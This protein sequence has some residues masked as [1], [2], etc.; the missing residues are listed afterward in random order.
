VDAAILI[1]LAAFCNPVKA[2]AQDP[3]DKRW[4]CGRLISKEAIETADN[5]L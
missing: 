2:V 5:F 3:F 1:S 4:K